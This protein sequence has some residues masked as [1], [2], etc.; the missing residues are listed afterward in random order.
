MGIRIDFDTL[1]WQAPSHGLRFKAF[2][3]KGQRLRLLEFS[4]G[5]AE[6]SWCAASHAFHVLEGTLTIETES[7]RTCLAAGDVGFIERG[8]RHKAS[9]SGNE[10]AL[11]LLFETD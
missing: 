3:R 8:E 7:G 1:P 6:A 4:N 2:V 10:R 5:F 11:L 9:V